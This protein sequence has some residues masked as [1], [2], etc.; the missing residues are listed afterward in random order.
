MLEAT[1]EVGMTP[2]VWLAA[3]LM[4]LAAVLLVTGIGASARWI[5]VI[6]VGS[7]IPAMPGLSNCQ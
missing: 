1:K 3:V 7:G 4:V 2:L 6:T 5:A